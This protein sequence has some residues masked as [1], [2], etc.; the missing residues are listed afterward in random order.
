MENYVNSFNYSNLSLV[1]ALR[2]LTSNF[3]LFGES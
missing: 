3:L 2:Y 1:D